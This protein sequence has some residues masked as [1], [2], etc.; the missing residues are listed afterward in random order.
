MTEEDW[1]AC[2]DPTPM[3][4]FLRGKASDRKFRLFA[5]ACCRS[6]IH[7]A[8]ERCR[9]ALAVA[10]QF[11][12]GLASEQAL[13]YA[14]RSAYDVFCEFQGVPEEV[15]S[16]VSLACSLETLEENSVEVAATAVALAT[17]G[18]DRDEPRHSRIRRAF[19]SFRRTGH[20]SA[21]H[22]CRCP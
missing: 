6:I 9:S 11:V 14:R 4:E 12:D 20:R 7:L 15:G 10:D 22:P 21:C 16:V 19:P 3:L 17:E 13:E 5:V 2:T 1:L 8:D 18:A